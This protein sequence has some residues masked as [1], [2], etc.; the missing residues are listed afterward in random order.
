VAKVYPPKVIEALSECLRTVYWYANDLKSLLIRCGVPRARVS[1]LDW[2]YKRNAVRELLDELASQGA[3][4]TPF[5]KSLIGAVVEQDDTYPHLSR[6]TGKVEGKTLVK[7]ARNAVLVLKDL[8]GAQAV[9]DH[10]EAARSENRTEAERLRSETAARAQ[11]LAK[12]KQRFLNL[13]AMSDPNRRGLDFQSWLRDLFDLHDLEPR[14]SFAGNGEQID[15]SIRIDGQTLLVEARWTIEMVAPEAVRD[16]VG[17]F[18]H[19]LDNT[20]GLMISVN[21]FTD[22]ASGKATS[23]GRLMTIFIDGRDLFPVV[24]GLIDLRQLL[25]RKLRHAAEKG[26]PMYRIGGGPG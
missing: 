15:G 26:E 17:K 4:G 3:A 16:F 25:S 21:R 18:E 9:V 22:A 24:D 14:G 19:K 7:E 23:G 6:I 13:A 10:A 20:L 1:A 11:A 2:T 12:L 5:V 8:L